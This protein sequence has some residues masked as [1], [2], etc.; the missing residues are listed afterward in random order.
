MSITLNKALATL[1]LNDV[2]H[3]QLKINIVLKKFYQ[4]SLIH[5]PDKP[6]VDT[7]MQQKLNEAYQ[8]IGD[9]IVHND[10]I[11]DD[12]EEETARHVYKSF[13]F[14]NI[15]ENIYSFTIKIDNHQ[16]QTTHIIISPSNLLPLMSTGHFEIFKH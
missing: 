8:F 12:S 10:D 16:L 11:R 5:H 13:N 4:M 7:I 15:K 9:F 1:G 2:H 6:G 14:N 3:H